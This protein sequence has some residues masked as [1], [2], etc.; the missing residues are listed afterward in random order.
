VELKYA[1][2]VRA[3]GPYSLK[4]AGDWQPRGLQTRANDAWQK[5]AR[6]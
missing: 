3:M 4:Y 6:R 5:R 1:Y 2:L